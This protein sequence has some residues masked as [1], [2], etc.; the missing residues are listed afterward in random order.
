VN[1]LYYYTNNAQAVS[2]S[3]VM[4]AFQKQGHQVYLLTMCEE[5]D[6]HKQVKKFGVKTFTY[7]TRKR[8]SLIFYL[9]HMQHLLRFIRANKCSIVYSHIQQANF[10]S[11][12]A[13][14]FSSA[15]F[16]LCRHHSDYAF[17][18]SNRNQKLFDR[19][20]NF[21]GKEF[22]VP[23]K[24]VYKQMVNVERVD[25]KKIHVI[26]YA[27]N[28]DEYEKP[29]EPVVKSIRESCK[30]RL[31]LLVIARLIPEKRHYLLFQVLN[32]LIKKGYDVKL[33]VLGDGVER[34]RLEN[35]VNSNNLGENVYM[36][37]HRPDIMNY[38]GACDVSVLISESEASN[39]VI[40]E[41]GLQKKPVIVCR[42]VGDFNEYIENNVNGFVIDKENPAPELE[43]LLGN[44][45]NNKVETASLGESLY[46]T[47]IDKFS[48]DNIIHQYDFFN[49]EG[50]S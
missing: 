49:S 2:L 15:R 16:I 43:K 36:L 40:K 8:N 34:G 33:I 13:Q 19:I 39:S 22:I 1:I 26:P 45:Y 9:R 21:F 3:S 27:Y 20:I 38:I 44:I 18:G 7:V 23:S 14:Y 28:F 30:C 29:N 32:N 47:V 31:L 42:N 46:R 6:L 4:I 24:K 5:G 17:R 12:F 35:Y 37:G 41:S 11:C 48:I 50:K 10:I 25:S